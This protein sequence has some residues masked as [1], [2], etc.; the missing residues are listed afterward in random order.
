VA[1]ALRVKIFFCIDHLR[2]DGTQRVLV[3]LVEGLA[4]RGHRL[5][6]W[7]LNDSWDAALV[8]RLCAA[9]ADVR[10]AGKKGLIS[11]TALVEA[12][13][14]LR[15][16][17]FDVAVTL[18]FA[19]DVIGRTLV[20]LARVPRLITSLRARNLNYT[21]WQRWLVRRT[22]RWADAVILNS[23]GVADYALYGEGAPADHIYVINNGL[24]MAD[25]AAPSDPA[26]KESSAALR[27]ELGVPVGVPLVGSV[28]RLDVQKGYDVLLSA[29]AAAPRPDAHLVLAGIGP[30]QAALE[31]QAASLGLNGRVHFAGYRRDVPRLLAGF[32]VYVQPSRWEGMPNALL[33]AM[34]AGCPIVASAVDGICELIDDGMHGWLTPPDDGTAL[35]RAI[36]V[37]LGERAEAARRG[38]A[39]RERAASCF[40]LDAMVNAWEKVLAGQ[41]PDRI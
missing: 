36:T 28:G 6:V 30:Q 15:R 39:A 24:R 19:S 35:R 7:C 34:A 12:Y 3:Q 18:L 23:A 4:V 25:Y 5:S 29:L 16:E 37:A 27:R 21:R 8:E 14:W 33:E 32:D 2:P 17:R 41:E 31:A 13:G 1:G 26:V 10:I 38:A 20:K 22:M 11:G 9:G 40:S